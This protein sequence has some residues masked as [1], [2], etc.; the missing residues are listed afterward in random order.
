[1]IDE[2]KVNSDDTVTPTLG[3]RW[4]EKMKGWTSKAQPLAKYESTMRFAHSHSGGPDD[5]ECEHHRRCA[6]PPCGPPSQ[7]AI[8]P[9][10]ATLACRS[11]QSGRIS[12]YQIHYRTC[13]Q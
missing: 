6:R 2:I 1:L 11:S 4:W 10:V 13:G 5:A 9:A 12:D 8:H 3:S 7:I